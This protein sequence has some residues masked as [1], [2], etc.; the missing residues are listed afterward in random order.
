MKRKITLILLLVLALSV[1]MF[2]G[3][4]GKE[5]TTTPTTDKVTT[6]GG[7]TAAPTTTQLKFPELP[8]NT[9]TL[10]VNIPEFNQTSD[11]KKIQQ[12]WQEKMEAYLGCKLSITWQRTPWAD[13]QNNELVMLQSGDVADISTCSKGTAV[14]EFGEEGILLNIA[15]YKSYMANFLK[16]A[17]DTN[18][19]ENFVFNEDG[20]LYYFMDGFY[21]AKDI[22]G[23]QSFT[24][25]AYRFDVLKANNLTPATTLAEFDTLVASLKTLIG[26]GKSTAK[27]VIMNSTKD[28][29]IYRGFVGIFHTWDCLYYNNKWSY[30]PIEDNF[31]EMLIY[32]NKLYKA[33]YIDPEFATADS[34]KGT[35][36]ATTGYAL[37]CPTL[38][39]GSSAAWNKAALDKTQQWGLAYLPKNEK[40]GTAWKWGSRQ[41][42][43][44]VQNTMGIYISAKTKYPEYVVAMIDYQYSDAMVELMNWGI[45]GETYTVAADGTKTFVDAIM[46]ADSPA[47]KVAEYGIMS[48]SVCRT[49][50]PFTPLDFEAMLAVSSIPEPWW[51]KTKGF[52][53]GKYWVE[54]SNNGGKESVSPYDRAPVTRLTT[55]DQTAVAQLKYGGVCE[56]YVRENALKFI[57]GDLDINNA[58]AWENYVK[59]VKSQTNGNFDD[60]LKTLTSK[61]VK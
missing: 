42:S 7:T 31:R 6:A 32:L 59:G 4:T 37:V 16:Y 14:N 20:S 13:Y 10:K 41:D 2:A 38:W 36:K 27:Y 52:Y 51:N 8:N 1:S 5:T 46:K 44:S 24:S 53:E 29:S 18:G 15:K 34:N 49:G 48:S 45:K 50:V 33:G 26:S 57:S 61:T 25:F 21:N 30:G 22:E 54:S 60:I 39:S 43:K 55:Q 12:L 47:T 40:Y 28:Y 35:E 23:A 58:T 17:N 11:G 56:T 9:L 3:C 19:G